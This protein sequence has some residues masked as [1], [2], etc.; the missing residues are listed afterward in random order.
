LIKKKS[1]FNFILVP[2]P[3]S[4]ANLLPN[5]PLNFNLPPPPTPFPLNLIANALTLGIPPP[6]T[7]GK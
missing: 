6:P 4:I 7:G 1:I 2:P 5:L 3:N